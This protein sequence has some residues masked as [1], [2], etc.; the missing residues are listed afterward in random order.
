M[1]RLDSRIFHLR[2]PPRL[3]GLSRIL[4]PRILSLQASCVSVVSAN[5]TPETRRL[6]PIFFHTRHSTLVPS[7]AWK[8]SGF[9]VP[10]RSCHVVLASKLERLF[11]F[12]IGPLFDFRGWPQRAAAWTQ[13]SRVRCYGRWTGSL[14]RRVGLLLQA[15]GQRGLRF[16][17]P[18]DSDPNQQFD[19][20]G[21]QGAERDRDPLQKQRLVLPRRDVIILPIT[22]TSTELLAEYI[23][24]QIK[25]KVRQNSRP[26]SIIWKSPSR[27]PAVKGEFFAATSSRA[28]SG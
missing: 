28:R 19:D 7:S 2:V 3:G 11:Q 24:G 14:G 5:L 6:K 20:S 23:A 22:D 1:V 8:S 16:F 21:S 13:L 18:S 12:R 15:V 4:S 25:R 9:L 10:S 26:P 17:G 27:K